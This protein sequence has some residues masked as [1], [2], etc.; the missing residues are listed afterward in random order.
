[1][2]LVFVTLVVVTMVLCTTAC[3]TTTGDDPDAAE[4][5]DRLSPALYTAQVDEICAATDAELAELPSPPE[6]ISA[7]DWAGEVAGTLRDEADDLDDIRVG[8][9]RRDDHAS[10]VENTVA[11]ADQWDEL[12]EALSGVDDPDVAATIGDI[13]TE[14]LELS[15]G[16]AD[17][18]DELGLSGCGV[19]D[20]RS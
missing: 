12:A 2:V 10:F 20:I 11:Q 8:A 6:E 19:R 7:V 5:G 15:L 18:A 4:E 3:S 9:S 14:I 1:M 13:R 16:R 17:L